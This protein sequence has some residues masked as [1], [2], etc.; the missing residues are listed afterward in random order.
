MAFCVRSERNINFNSKEK[1][2]GPGQYLQLSSKIILNNKRKFPPFFSSSK[3]APFVK[4][5][6]IPGPGSYNLDK[7]CKQSLSQSNFQ[8]QSTTTSYEKEENNFQEI[9]TNYNSVDK[10]SNLSTIWQLSNFSS[11]S[12][13]N[14]FP[15]KNHSCSSKDK[16]I[17]NS[18]IYK[19]YNYFGN[20]TN[21]KFI[22]TDIGFLS[23]S[24][25]FKEKKEK[26]SN[27]PGPGYYYES[28]V[29]SNSKTDNKTKNKIKNGKISDKSGILGRIVSIPSKTMN[30]YFIKGIETQNAKS[31]NNSIMKG[32]DSNNSSFFSIMPK[33]LS[34]INKDQANHESNLEP[35]M[36]INNK[37]IENEDNKILDNK[38][39][40]LINEK[41]FEKT[42]S[43]TSEF[44][45][46]GSY[47]VS[48]I[49]KNKNVINWS[50]GFDLEKIAKK[51][52]CIKK[53][54]L[55]EE[56][57]RNGDF[58]PTIRTF[59]HGK[60]EKINPKKNKILFLYNLRKIKNNVLHNQLPNSS[61]SSSFIPDKTQIP[62]PGYYDEEGFP[63]NKTKK[64]KSFNLGNDN[65]K[66]VPNLNYIKY[67]YGQNK[68]DPGFGSHCERAVNKSKSLEDLGPFTYF[69]EK[70]KFDPGKK[71]TLYK[72]IILGKTD[73]S[74][75]YY[76]NYDIYTQDLADES[77]ENDGQNYDTNLG[78][79]KNNLKINII[80][81]LNKN[82]KAENLK[83]KNTISN[84]S[85]ESEK[86]LFKQLD[87]TS[88][89]FFSRLNQLPLVELD[90]YKYFNNNPGPGDYNLD[91]QFIKKSFSTNQMMESK[92]ERFKKKIINDNPGPGT[93][94]LGHDFKKRILLKKITFKKSSM[95]LIK[96][97]KIK[98]II[99]RNKKRNET[100]GVGLYN[101]DNKNSLVYKINSKA[102]S[103]Q[104]YYSPFLMSSSRFNKEKYKNEVSSADYDPYKF[105]N[106]QKNNQ[107][108]VFNKAE[109]FNKD[110]DLLVGP[111]SYKLRTQWNKKS[112]NRLFSPLKEEEN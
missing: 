68:I 37:Y 86:L 55:L 94:Q 33:K 51:H 85:T 5:N 13:Y 83:L 3:R 17:Q 103:R 2:P 79:N 87:I 92:T 108:M 82:Q 81:D 89:N 22:G 39:Q 56:F 88:R 30:G 32:S 64:T 75:T 102:N 34:K 14:N 41:K 50:K 78:K 8:I 77:Q 25:R 80:D 70:N 107:F 100:P 73:M 97:Q 43:T 63:F 24:N 19:L 71:N 101:L 72:N 58:T 4:L 10:N 91:H 96:E 110:N 27:I 28:I 48:L 23:Q 18:Q 20:T 45:G 11:S 49:E 57:K 84:F 67:L 98:N 12:K 26:D 105:E 38:F 106:I 62:G 76:N 53:N 31:T 36:V 1:Y 60:I 47:D 74:R 90:R 65:S 9:V 6:N 44:I 61:R 15:N 54:K 16:A 40:L 66:K 104:G 35:N 59:H 112:Y 93:Y 69:Q 99:A 29:G 95:D 109:R 111:G 42:N 52:N 46:P 7:N 21:N